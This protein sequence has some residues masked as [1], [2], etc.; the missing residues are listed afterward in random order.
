MSKR[1]LV[2]E[3]AFVATGRGVLVLPRFTATESFAPRFPVRLRFADGTERE[4]SAS[5]DVAHSRGTLAPW[6]MYRLFDVTPEDLP[7][8]TEL[9]SVA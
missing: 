6:A 9:W 7:S 4:V 1:L 5:V 3:E 8:G 2:V